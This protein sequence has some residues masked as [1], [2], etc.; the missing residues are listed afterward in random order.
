M[1]FSLNSQAKCN[2]HMKKLLL[3]LLFILYPTFAMQSELTPEQLEKIGNLLI[4]QH[5]NNDN[6]KH[7]FDFYPKDSTAEDHSS[8]CQLLIAAGAQTKKRNYWNPGFLDPFHCAF[9]A[10]QVWDILIKNG[11]NIYSPTFENKLGNPFHYHIKDTYEVLMS[12]IILVPPSE[13][14]IESQKLIKTLLLCWKRICPTLPRDMRTIILMQLAPDIGNVMIFRR[15]QGKSIPHIFK[16]ITILTLYYSTL[17]RQI[18]PILNDALSKEIRTLL[19]HKPIEA[20]E[21]LK[22]EMFKNIATRL[23]LPKLL[24]NNTDDILELNIKLL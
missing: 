23:N 21:P 10:E 22:T 6:A 4:V 14:L 3:I 15:L 16:E 2:E 5:M 18:S 17:R 24:C 19:I 13:E 11:L 7:G 12:K 9:N 1:V 8:I 20:N